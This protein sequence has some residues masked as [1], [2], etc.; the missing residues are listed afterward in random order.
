MQP[1]DSKAVSFA[2]ASYTDWYESVYPSLCGY[3]LYLKG[4]EPDAL[5]ADEFEKRDW[6]I[7]FARLSTWQD[8][9]ESFT[10]RL[11]YQIARSIDGAYPDYAF[12]PPWTDVE[13]FDRGGVPWMLGI[14]SKRGAAAFDVIGI[15]NS[16]VQELVNL[17]PMLEHSGIPVKK[18]VRMAS[19][20]VPLV[21]LGGANAI[22]TSLLFEPDPMVDAIFAGESVELVREVFCVCA[23][24]KRKGLSKP[25]ILANLEKIEGVILPDNPKPTQKHFAKTP[26]TSALMIGAPKP[27]SATTAGNGVIQISEGC[28]NFCSFCSESFVRKPY[29]EESLG[30]LLR[31][32]YSMKKRDGLGNIDLFSFNFASYGDFYTLV[33]NLAAIYP[34]IGLK[35]QRMDTVADDPRLL[36]VLHVLGKA[37]LTFG[38]E[39]ISERLRIYLDKGIDLSTIMRGME[40]VIRAPVREVKLFFILTGLETERDFE[41]L[42]LLAAALK[43]AIS[44]AG[45]G[46]RLVFSATALVRFPWTPLEWETSPM[47]KD[48]QSLYDAFEKIVKSEGFEARAAAPAEEFYVSQVIARARSPKVV[49]ALRKAQKKTGYLYYM[50]VTSKFC[51]ALR[52]NLRGEGLDPDEAAGALPLDD[53]SAPWIMLGSGL[54][55]EF[56]RHKALDCRKA[57]E[58]TEKPRMQI[59]RP[60]P[61]SSIGRIHEKIGKIIDD[62]R[63]GARVVAIGV[64]I[65]RGMKGVPREVAGSL[66]AS[67]L[68]RAWEDLVP[69]YMGFDGSF[70]CKGWDYPALFG[71][72]ILYLRFTAEGEALLGAHLAEDGAKARID[73][74]LSPRMEISATLP[75]DVPDCV[76]LEIHSPYPFKAQ[77]FLSDR[78]IKFT[79]R[80]PE[81]S[82]SVC[83]IA[84][85]SLKK[86]PIKRL[87]VRSE[88]GVYNVSLVASVDFDARDMLTNAFETPTKEDW[89]RIDVITLF[90]GKK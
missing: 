56:L 74:F 35:S 15:S 59:S 71:M 7:L 50:H 82:L 53:E 65:P 29:R 51:N 5:S 55:R 76:A 34:T 27:L 90:H 32:A 87:S 46:P 24:G 77:Q 88:S 43:S 42:R 23:D 30:V 6:R 38:I 62:R 11:L 9:L 10:H 26:D 89:V 41:E 80:K 13:I 31:D 14:N 44:R 86:S 79:M 3:G 21:I 81:S 75:A 8:T 84:A 85:Q 17:A 60:V 2:Q 1:E 52:E 72:D 20:D 18:S 49:E 54:K 69:H 83:E 48:V 36:P 61:V 37:T 33:E 28:R 19:A 25:E 70:F 63:K 73:A 45:R 57:L 68:M 4:G 39:G 64:E 22:H 40:A 67:A 66:L 78:H 16:I 12:L 58:I 47:V